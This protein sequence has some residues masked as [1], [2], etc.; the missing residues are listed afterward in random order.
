MDRGQ[1]RT[2]AARGRP[3]A[4]GGAG[5]AR[6]GREAIELAGAA[7]PYAGGEVP[8]ALGLYLHVPFCTVMCPY[9]HFTR[10]PYDA[11]LATRYV[12]A[13]A[14]EIVRAGRGERVDT[15]YFGGG[16][17]S[18]LVPADVGR[19]LDACRQAFTVT[20]DAEVTLEANPESLSRATLDGYRAA[21]V[22]RLSIG[23]QSFCDAALQRLGRAHDAA[24][25]RRA[26]RE[27]RA[28]GFETVSVDLML[29]L[30]GETIGEALASVDALAALG[31]DH[32]SL[33]LL[34]LWPGA[35]L[36][37]TAARAG[38][39]F[40]DDEDAATVYEAALER[41]E[42]AGYLH[43]E[44]SNVA[45]PGRWSRHNLKYWTGGDWYGFGVAAHSTVRGER[46]AN[47]ARVD[48]YLARLEA[49]LS[50]RVGVET[51][52]AA[53]RLEEALFM[54]LRLVG[55]VDEAGLARRYGVDVW[56]RYG[57]ELQPYVE[58]GY[59]VRGGGRLRLTRR[60]LLVSTAILSVFVDAPGT[61]K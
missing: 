26:Y 44:I 59:L 6:G 7:L 50:V 17:P 30:P 16:T 8:D 4:T 47:V 12:A 51:L 1:G 49:G 34:E 21:G 55:G 60:G 33:Y 53:A 5:A 35:P 18:L 13:L 37:E 19:L 15:V 36:A 24:R 38:W 23:A 40:P 58:A 43:Y 56:A 28:A 54:G 14:R 41:L 57:P 46:W 22:T 11:G 9:C 42:A 25:A 39:R 45:R 3:E 20:R 32:A 52:G 29:G 10:G 2:L 61:V 48:E 31:P 27:A